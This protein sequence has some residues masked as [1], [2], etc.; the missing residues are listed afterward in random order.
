MDNNTSDE[1]VTELCEPLL[2]EDIANLNAVSEHIAR[3][4][5]ARVSVHPDSHAHECLTRN[6]RNLRRLVT[7]MREYRQTTTG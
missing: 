1:T 7:A 4:E 3:M 6:I 2:L 5:I